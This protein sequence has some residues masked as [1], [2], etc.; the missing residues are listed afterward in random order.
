M[1]KNDTLRKSEADNLIRRSNKKNSDNDSAKVYYDADNPKKVIDMIPEED[2]IQ[3]RQ[4]KHTAE[5][6]Y[7]IKLEAIPEG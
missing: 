6:R 2:K 7:E 3:L 1:K 5:S 4:I